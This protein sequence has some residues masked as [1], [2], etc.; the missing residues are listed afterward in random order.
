MTYGGKEDLVFQKQL[1]SHIRILPNRWHIPSKLYSFLLP[2]L[3]RRELRE[4]EVYKTNQLSGSWAAVVAKWMYK[5]KLVVR[6]GYELLWFLEQQKA[7]WLKR[8]VIEWF[9]RLAY[10]ASDAIIVAAEGDKEF[11]IKRFPIASEKITVIPNYIDVTLFKP[12]NLS[13]KE[14]SII[15]VGRLAEQKN[16][17]NL[18]TAIGG[19]NYHLI[20][21]GT[22]ILRS[23]LEKVAR[24]VAAS[25]EF[26]GSIANH[27]LPQ[28]LN[29][30]Q[31][32]IL[33]S[34]YEGCPKTLLEAMACGVPC[35]GTNV[36]GIKEVVQDGIN[37]ILSSID[38]QFLQQTIERVMI[39]TSLQHAI[40]EGARATIIDHFSLEECLKKEI[41]IYTKITSSI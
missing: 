23:R 27:L 33:P 1:P 10:R 3:Y 26:K 20:I 12:L 35:I 37:G 15:F 40:G 14:N 2:F 41:K 16:L 19:T 30:A 36:V 4:V 7:G 9:E 5:K 17:E 6:C 34:L 21:I 38:A 39:D 31:I 18:I 8:K 32:F 25:V 13:K 11:I 24:E 29:Q 22:G 28:E